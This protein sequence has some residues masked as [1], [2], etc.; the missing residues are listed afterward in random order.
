MGAAVVQM[1]GHSYPYVEVLAL[2][3]SRSV[4]FV[5][6]QSAASNGRGINQRLF[7]CSLL[8]ESAKITMGP[9]Q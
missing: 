8:E 1:D 3:T 2:I 4:R 6:V 5:T 7:R 9:G